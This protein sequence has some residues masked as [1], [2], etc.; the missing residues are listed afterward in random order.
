MQLAAPPTETLAHDDLVAYEIVRY[1]E[2]LSIQVPANIPIVSFNN[3][4]ICLCESS[5]N[6]TRYFNI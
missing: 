2:E 1:L 6:F 3:H 5:I 4:A